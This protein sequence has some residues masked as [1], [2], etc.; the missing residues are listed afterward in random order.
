[1]NNKIIIIDG[2]S[3]SG[4]TSL[5]KNL[6]FYPNNIVIEEV[7]K[8]IRNNKSL[9]NNKTLISMPTN[10]NEEV[11]SQI[12]LLE[13]EIE[14]IKRAYYVLKCGKNAILDRS[15]LSTVAIA[16]SF[17]KN[18]D[19]KGAYIH[20]KKLL[21]VYFDFIQELKLDNSLEYIFLLANNDIIHQRNDKR[22]K[23]LDEKWIDENLINLQKE[24]FI[25]QKDSCNATIIDTSNK[26]KEEVFE[27][28]ESLKKKVMKK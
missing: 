10:Y 28:V 11:K 9:F 4:K 22:E 3:N 1:M 13:A 6:A 25:S 7:P 8:F 24:F 15:F 17:D 2:I 23:A 18:P 19:F 16:Y 12:F 5:C 27:I 26:S 21:K 20:S 14:R